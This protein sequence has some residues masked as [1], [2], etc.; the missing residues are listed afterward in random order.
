VTW[1]TT[2]AFTKNVNKLVSLYNQSIVSDVGNNLFINENINSVYNYVFDG[3]W[4]ESERALALTFNQLPGQARVKDLNGDGRIDAVNDRT[5][6][7]NST[8]EWSGS[9]NS[10]LRVG[11]FDFA[12]SVITNQNVL[13]LSNFHDNF[14]DVN[15]RGRQKA[16]LADWYVPANGAGVPAQ[17]SNTYPQPRNEGQYWSSNMAFYRDA[18][19]VKIKN[20][21]L[22]Y[23]LPNDVLKTFK[24]KSFRI[25]ANVLNPF[26]ITNYDGYDP[27]WAGASLGLGRTAS[28]TYQMGV[29]IRL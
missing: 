23:S 6:L 15:D 7:G 17:S 9:L 21:A 20:I 2:F 27:E 14:A 16:D 25:Y 11:N 3:I 29:S 12:V 24:M 18:S 22:G 19:F 5:V 1:E 26:V 8:P 28:I 13:V 4:Q 10:N